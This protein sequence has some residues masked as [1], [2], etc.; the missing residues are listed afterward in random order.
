MCNFQKDGNGLR[1]A[2]TIACE[3]DYLAA[4]LRISLTSTSSEGLMLEA[5]MGGYLK[6]T[7]RALLLKLIMFSLRTAIGHALGFWFKIF[8]GTLSTKARLKKL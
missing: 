5:L 1:A 6:R 7:K 2:F 4:R 8:A 3:S